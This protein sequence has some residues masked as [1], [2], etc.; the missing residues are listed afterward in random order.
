MPASLAAAASASR[1]APASPA[2]RKLTIEAKP[3]FLISGTAVAFTAPA[4][5][6][7]VSSLTKLVTPS[8]VSLVAWACWA[9]AGATARE[10]AR[11][12]P[13]V[14]KRYDFIASLRNEPQLC[15]AA[16]GRAKDPLPAAPAMDYLESPFLR[17]MRQG[18]AGAIQAR[19]G[20]YRPP[21][22]R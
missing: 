7:V 17:I 12:S 21:G 9:G 13:V 18:L 10:A 15:N 2:C 16:L 19:T 20:R 22:N 3:I 5:A 11:T 4:Q 8:T 1:S 14:N 6:T